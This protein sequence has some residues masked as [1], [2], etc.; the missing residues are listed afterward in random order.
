MRNEFRLA[1]VAL[2][3]G[4]MALAVSGFSQAPAPADQYYESIRH[5]DLGMLNALVTTKGVK[6]KDK[7]ATTPLHYAAATAASKPCARIL[8]AGADVNARNDFGATPLMWAVAEPEKVRLLVDGRRRRQREIQDGPHRALS[9]GGQRW[10]R[11]HRALP[12]G[13]WRQTR[14]ARI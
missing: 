13:A 4:L 3:A 10:L 12:A 9:R 7:H 1:V 6:Y 14:E 5:N 8:S 11:A 2:L